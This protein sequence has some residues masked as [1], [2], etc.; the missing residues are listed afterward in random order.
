MAESALTC[1]RCMQRL[2]SNRLTRVISLTA[3]TASFRALL[4]W[5]EEG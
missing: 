3:V 5:Q 1:A 2:S 4:T